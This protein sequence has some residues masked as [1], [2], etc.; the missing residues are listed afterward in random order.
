MDST[1]VHLSK[2]SQTC[3]IDSNGVAFTCPD[4]YR[5]VG[6]RSC[7]FDRDNDGYY[8]SDYRYWWG[9]GAGIVVTVVVIAFF[10]WR[11]VQRNRFLERMRAGEIP[12]IASQGQSQGP[13]YGHL[14][15]MEPFAGHFVP[16]P[17]PHAATAA[18]F[19]VVPGM[20]IPIVPPSHLP[21][22]STPPARVQSPRR[23]SWDLEVDQSHGGASSSANASAATSSSAA[24]RV[25]EL[26]EYSPSP[27]G[28]SGPVPR[29]S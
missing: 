14:V 29:K 18:T 6:S 19:P 25:D 13:G 24:A 2:R 8:Y 17:P 7:V 15:P 4:N 3:S 1:L 16:S 9:I 12:E 22:N 20:A 11:R 27:A 23:T 21:P 5:C 10:V 28:T 26:P